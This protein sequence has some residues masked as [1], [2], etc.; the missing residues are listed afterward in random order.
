M[1]SGITRGMHVSKMIFLSRRLKDG[2]RDDEPNS[3]I[4]QKQ[5]LNLR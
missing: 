5:R 1:C 2:R 3:F 4:N